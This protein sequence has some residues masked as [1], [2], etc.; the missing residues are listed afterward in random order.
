M[1]KDLLEF[2]KDLIG[3]LKDSCYKSSILY[4]AAH[5][6]NEVPHCGLVS[7]RIVKLG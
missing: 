7:S 4:L 2:I 5:Y 6:M 1:K 3:K